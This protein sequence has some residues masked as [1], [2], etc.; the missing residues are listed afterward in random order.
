MYV[1]IYK[2]TAC[3]YNSRN[4]NHNNIICSSP[5]LTGTKKKKKRTVLYIGKG[6]SLTVYICS[7]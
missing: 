6:G 7:I 1:Y 5:A 3:R 4:N 2:P